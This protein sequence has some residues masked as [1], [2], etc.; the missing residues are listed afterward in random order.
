MLYK[1]TKER[2]FAMDQN[3]ELYS[4]V[5]SSKSGSYEGGSGAASW[6]DRWAGRDDESEEEAPE[7]KVLN[8]KV[9]IVDQMWLWTISTR[10]SDSIVSE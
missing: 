8:G 3:G 4:Q 6:R 1:L 10:K 9:L 5:S 2:E 7:D